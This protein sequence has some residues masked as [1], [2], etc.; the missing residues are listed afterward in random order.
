[1]LTI[2]M[3][4][5]III[6]IKTAELSKENRYA[7]QELNQVPTEYTSTLQLMY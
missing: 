3:M 4:I 2:M 6:I 1:M 7:D 5:M